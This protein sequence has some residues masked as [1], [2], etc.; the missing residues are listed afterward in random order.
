M[1]ARK[2]TP[3]TALKVEIKPAAPRYSPS[4]GRLDAETL[5]KAHEEGLLLRRAIEKRAAKML[6]PSSGSEV[7]SRVR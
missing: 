2:Q 3:K 1:L 7:P 6:V 4:A 5:R